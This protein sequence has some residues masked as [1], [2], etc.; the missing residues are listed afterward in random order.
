MKMNR[1]VVLLTIG[2]L[3]SLTL[4]STVSGSTS[5]RQANFSNFYL[6]NQG[7]WNQAS[8]SGNLQINVCN[9]VNGSN[10]GWVQYEINYGG[11]SVV[12]GGCAPGPCSN[13]TEAGVQNNSYLIL[14]FYPSNI[15]GIQV[16]ESDSQGNAQQVWLPYQNGYQNYQ[17]ALSCNPYFQF[18]YA[19]N[20]TYCNNSQGCSAVMFRI[21]ATPITINVFFSAPSS[22]Y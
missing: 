6:C 9:K 18:C 7:Q 15:Y 5:V 2:F 13:P 8:N 22:Y 4:I 10:P 21:E 3:L 12:S 17:T 11:A 16:I 1:S 14:R 20:Q 19:Q